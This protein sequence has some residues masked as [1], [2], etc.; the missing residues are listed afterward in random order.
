MN[1][2]GS[3]SAEYSLPQKNDI[4]RY[5]KENKKWFIPAS[6]FKDC[7]F[8]YHEAYISMEQPL[9]AEY[10]ADYI[11][12][13]RNS[14]GYHIVLMEFENV[15]MEFRVIK[16]DRVINAGG[17]QLVDVADGLIGTVCPH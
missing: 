8:G 14:I 5:I 7:D 12:L 4:Q 13:G 3:P 16:E 10:R 9:G 15:N 2:G 17:R 11:L 1:I 6:I